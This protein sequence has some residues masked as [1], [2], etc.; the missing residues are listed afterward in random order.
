[1]AEKELY[2]RLEKIRKHDY[3]LK[4]ASSMWLGSSLI[5]FFLFFPIIIVAL[6][7][8][9]FFLIMGILHYYELENSFTK[10]R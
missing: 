1:M 10:R 9:I 4:V 2:T 5:W 3:A 8:A 6:I 7:G